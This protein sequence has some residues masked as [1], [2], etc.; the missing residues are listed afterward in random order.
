MKI[1]N[2]ERPKVAEI[3]ERLKNRLTRKKA[4]PT[5]D[6]NMIEELVEYNDFSYVM[7]FGDDFDSF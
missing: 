1:K 6:P 3:K 5:I 4:N 2:V 7:D